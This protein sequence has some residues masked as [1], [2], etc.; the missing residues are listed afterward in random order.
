M[1]AIAEPAEEAA[2]RAT[3]AAGASSAPD[4]VLGARRLTWAR[5]GLLK[6]E[7]APR[8][9]ALGKPSLGNWRSEKQV[10]AGEAAAA[11]W[12]SQKQVAAGDRA[13]VDGGWQRQGA[14]EA[15]ER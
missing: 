6:A 15:S 5:S 14:R 7:W 9:R 12:F 2:G 1:A 10:A 4:W 3:A 11:G 13:A 8:A